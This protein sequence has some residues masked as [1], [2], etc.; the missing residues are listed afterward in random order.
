MTSARDAFAA[1]GLCPSC[2]AETGGART[3]PACGFQTTG[4][5]NDDWN[6]L[7]PGTVL[8]ER[9]VAGRALGQGGFGV[10]YLGLDLLL[11]TKLAVKEYYP[12]GISVRNSE[13][14]SVRHAS[15]DLAEDFKRGMEKFLEEA[16][17]L[18]R[19]E[20]HPNVVSVRD[21][22]EENGTAYMVMNY[23]EGKTLLD[24]LKERGG[25]IPFGE[26]MSIL[27]PLMDALDEIHASGT[28]HRDLSP[29]N[30]FLTRYGQP[31][32]LDFGASKS[33]LSLMQQ[34]SHSVI[35]KRGYSPP[36]QYQSRG[37]LGPWS[38]VYGMAA[39][40]YRCVTGVT[41]PDAFDRMEED[42]LTPPGKG[43]AQ[44]P[45]HA[46]SA[47]VRALSVSSKN[48]P[49]S[50][51]EF[52]DG[53]TGNVPPSFAGRPPD[54]AEVRPPAAAPLQQPA[55]LSPLAPTLPPVIT[56]RDGSELLLIPAGE[57][58]MGDGKDADNPRHRVHLDAY[59]IGKYC[60]TNAQYLRFVDETGHL[61][62]EDWG[63]VSSRSYPDG[64]PD[65]PVVKVSWEDA[66]AYARWAECELPTEAQW[67]KAARGPKGYIYPWGNDWDSSKCRKSQFFGGGTVPV[68]AYPQGVS[69]Y[70][71]YQ[72]AGNVWEWCFDWYGSDYYTSPD[73]GRNPGGPL[74]GS[75]RVTRGG[76]WWGDIPSVFR[77]AYRR[78]DVPS[79]RDADLGFRLARPAK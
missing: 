39:T 63:G 49:Q 73:A 34:R 52:R 56:A 41:P 38:D 30:I 54:A 60:V 62:P 67:E 69:G 20:E 12:S 24:H 1:S 14:R 68:D 3:C 48:R 17:T 19:F 16:R 44:L 2:F 23:V 11:H 35:L 9:Y 78:R 53:L 61:P 43:G 58:D 29:D 57:F 13:S 21:F 65:H 74:T 36:E 31:K 59:Y 18:A 71:T 46:D 51:R 40:L 42:I 4:S 6:L 5:E 15:S 55:P 26:A 10:T 77:G 37:R 76:S 64:K 75:R 32:L 50:M 45:G 27:S 8:R 25:R 66:M 79:C 28:I 22:F 47:I 72:Q 33:A 7:R 70:G